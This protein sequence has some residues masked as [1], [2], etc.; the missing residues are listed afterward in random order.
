MS[1]SLTVG[2]SCVKS[3]SL[4]VGDFY[5][6]I[7]RSVLH[8]CKTSS[9]LMNSSINKFNLLLFLLK[10]EKRMKLKIL[11]LFVILSQYKTFAQNFWEYIGLEGYFIANIA[12]DNSGRLYA[13]EWQGSGDSVFFSDDFGKTWY[14]Y[15]EVNDSEFV[16]ISSI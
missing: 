8:F 13:T 7:C 9:L 11:I 2:F 10:S 14:S 12:Q 4:E 3:T 16:N 1:F 5:K 6:F 15:G